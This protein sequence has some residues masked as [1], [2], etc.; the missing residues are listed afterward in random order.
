MKELKKDKF[1]QI[2]K[3]IMM[4]IGS[5]DHGFYQTRNH[6]FELKNS[7]NHTTL[8]QRKL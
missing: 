8:V 2:G 7:N 1:I 3:I 4:I 6:N 5:L